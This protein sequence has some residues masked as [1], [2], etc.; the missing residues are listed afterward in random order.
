MRYIEN[1]KKSDTGIIESSEINA[2]IYPQMILSEG[3]KTDHS[4]TKG[5]FLTTGTGELGIY[6][7]KKKN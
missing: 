7:K 6:I 4:M 5:V 2:C 3:A 1:D